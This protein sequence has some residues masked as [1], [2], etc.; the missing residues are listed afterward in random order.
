MPS[1][2]CT[3]FI[4]TRGSVA[5]LYG[6]WNASGDFFSDMWRMNLSVFTYNGIS[7]YFHMLTIIAFNGETNATSQ[8]KA[9]SDKKSR[10]VAIAVG[11]VIPIVVILLW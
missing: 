9:S 2:R 6:G 7:T 5:Y 3:P 8:E 11:I 1:P 10:T 4:A